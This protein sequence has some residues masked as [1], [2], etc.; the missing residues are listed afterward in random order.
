MSRDSRSTIRALQIYSLLKTSA[1]P[2][3]NKIW[4]EWIYT[5]D[6]NRSNRSLQHLIFMLKKHSPTPASYESEAGFNLGGNRRMAP[7]IWG[8]WQEI[9]QAQFAAGSPLERW[10]FHGRK[11]LTDLRTRF[12]ANL[13]DDEITGSCVITRSHQNSSQP[14][15]LQQALVSIPLAAR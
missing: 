15:P 9:A 7:K 11:A 1:L 6:L 13:D 4:S 3:T 10:L 5:E 8:V 14:H 12:V 2:E